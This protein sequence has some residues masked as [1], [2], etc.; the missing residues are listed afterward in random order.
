MLLKVRRVFW[1][2]V[3]VLC[4]KF[5][6][7]RR[8]YRDTVLNVHKCFCKV[9]II[10]SQI[11]IKHKFCPQTFEK[12]A[13]VKFHENSSS[14]SRCFMRTDRQAL[15]SWRSLFAIFRTRLKM[16]LRYAVGIEDAY[17]QDVTVPVYLGTVRIKSKVKCILVQALRLC[18]GR[19]ACRGSRGIALSFHDHAP[20]GV[21]GQRHA[22][23]ALYPGKTL[24]PLYRGLGG[25]QVRSGQVWKISPPQGFDTRNVSP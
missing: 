22:S 7:P 24:Y 2:S 8:I 4:A 25:P 20:E 10:S 13:D 21:R 18:T 11:L 14:A 3:P 9:T 19:T 1:I 23:A 5:L 6:I 12:Y 16:R 17:Q 15:R